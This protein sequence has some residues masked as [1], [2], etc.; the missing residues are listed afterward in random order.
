[1]ARK[2]PQMEFAVA[3]SINETVFADGLG[4]KC[5]DNMELLG[6][7]TD[8]EAKS[9]MRNCI[10]FIFPTFYEGF[11]IPPLEAISAGAQSIIVSDTEIMH[12]IFGD[13]VNYIDPNNYEMDI[14]KFFNITNEGKKQLLNKYSW[15]KSAK[16]LYEFLC[17]LR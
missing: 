9:L 8:E 17:T 2:N 15:E 12:E 4:F 16:V 10:S 1:M 11:G 14:T 5:P 7:V 3:G 13:N 6:Y